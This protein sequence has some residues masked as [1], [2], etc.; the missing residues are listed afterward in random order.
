MKCVMVQGTSS[1]AGKTTVAALLCRH[2]ARQGLRVAPFKAQNLSLNSFVT[3]R[4]EEMGISQAFQAWACGREPEGDMNPILLKPRS[5]GSCQIILSGRP[6]ADVGRGGA[7]A[8]REALLKAVRESYGRLAASNDVVII[9]GSGSP[10]E[11]NLR[12]TDIANMTTAE[13]ARS[14]VILVGDIERGGVFAA[15]YGTYGLLE[16][17]HRDLVKAFVINRFRGDASILGPGMAKLQDL[18]KVPCLGVLPFV[19][20]RFPSEDSLDLGRQQGRGASGEDIREAWLKNLDQFYD[21]S[22][23]HIDYGILEAI[24]N[25]R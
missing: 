23:S 3:A 12:S 17:R 13:M 14:P 7:T 11:I 9:E 19:D 8:H 2:F 22:R 4:G 25:G 15:V 16:E 24:V 1:G 6:Y 10:A 18:M 5:E 21:T 20:L